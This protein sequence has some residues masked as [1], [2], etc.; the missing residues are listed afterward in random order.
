MLIKQ[1]NFCENALIFH[2]Q[3]ERIRGTPLF[4]M[5]TRKICQTILRI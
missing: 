4:R 5:E 1:R 2:P 3:K